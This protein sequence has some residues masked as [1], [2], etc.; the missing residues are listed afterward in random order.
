M[1]YPDY[2][3]LAQ[4]SPVW[5]ELL[6]DITAAPSLSV[7]RQRLKTFLLCRLHLGTIDTFLQWSWKQKVIWQLAELRTLYSPAGRSNLRLHDLAGYSTSKSFLSLEVTDLYLTQCAF[8]N[9]SRQM[10]QSRGANVTDDRPHHVEMC[11]NR[12]KRCAARAIPPNVGHYSHYNKPL[13]E[14]DDG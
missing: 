10:G 7:F 13:C 1:A 11:W 6:S 4:P 14:D 12:R 2:S 5:N 8:E 9:L 3:G